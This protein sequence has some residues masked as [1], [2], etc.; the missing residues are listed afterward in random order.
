MA[1]LRPYRF[2]T[3]ILP[4]HAWVELRTENHG[5]FIPTT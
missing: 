1:R 3:H 5:Y 4:R 2:V